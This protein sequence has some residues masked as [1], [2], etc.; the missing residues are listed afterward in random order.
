MGL[1]Y[2]A[3]APSWTRGRFSGGTLLRSAIW[4]MAGGA[5]CSLLVLAAFAVSL[6]YVGGLVIVLLIS[7]LA[8]PVGL[9]I[10]LLVGLATCGVYGCGWIVYRGTIGLPRVSSAVDER[11]Y[12]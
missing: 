1:S 10:G 6:G 8:V 2:L 5:I 9:L 4:G 12:P 7:F 3:F 11:S